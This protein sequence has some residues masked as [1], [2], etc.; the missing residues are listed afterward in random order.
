MEHYEANKLRFAK[1]TLKR[2]GVAVDNTTCMKVSGNSMDPVMPDGCTVGVDTSATQIK[3]GDIYAIHYYGQ[4]QVKCLYRNDDGGVRIRSYNDSE[5]QD[6]HC[7]QD[8]LDQ[9]NVLG[10]V[11]WWSVLC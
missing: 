5:Y 2:M 3:D 10:R 9:L 1:S 7:T 8:E 6:V 4:L 11:F